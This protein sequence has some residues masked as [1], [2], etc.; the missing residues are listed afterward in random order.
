LLIRCGWDYR[1]GRQGAGHLHWAVIEHH[2]V[3]DEKAENTQ[4]LIVLPQPGEAGNAD[5][6]LGKEHRRRL[7]EI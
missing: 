5:V 7:K 3:G 6:N 1:R 4:Q 2:G